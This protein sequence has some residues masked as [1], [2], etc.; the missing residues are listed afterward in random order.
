VIMAHVECHKHADFCHGLTRKDF[1]TVVAYRD[2]QNIGST[3]YMRDE[4]FYLQWIMLSGP[5]IELRNDEDVKNAK[6]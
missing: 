5:L 6:K 2:G 1:H 3:Y 4:D